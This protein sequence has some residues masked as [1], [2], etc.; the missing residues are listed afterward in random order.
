MQSSRTRATSAHAASRAAAAKRQPRVPGIDQAPVTPTIALMTDT[1]NAVG[2]LH[3]AT[4][5][6]NVKDMERAVRFWSV[7]LGYREREAQGE[8][9][10][11]TLARPG[12]RRLQVS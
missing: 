11:M 4:V 3:L 7:A 9:N 1:N 8:P 12:G 2:E 6:L 5:V 10:F